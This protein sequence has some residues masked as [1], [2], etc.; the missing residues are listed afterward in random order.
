[1]KFRGLRRSQISSKIKLCIKYFKLFN[2]IVS[3]IIRWLVVLDSTKI[4]NYRPAILL[5][6]FSKI[7]ERF[8]HENLTNC[9]NTFI[10]KFISAYC[11]FYS[12][13]HILTHLIENWKKSP[14]E[15]NYWCCLNGLVNV[16]WLHISLPSHC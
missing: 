15:K 9:V 4:E 11:K 3:I 10:L 7:Y 5:N 14:D 2:P 1:M 8:L 6:K 13:N 12:T 16:F